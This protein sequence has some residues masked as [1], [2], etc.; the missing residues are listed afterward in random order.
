MASKQPLKL[1]DIKGK[2]I[3]LSLQL[4]SF[5]KYS[6][7]RQKKNILIIGEANSPILQQ[8]NN[9]LMDKWNIFHL[10]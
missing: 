7:F 9:S 8:L 5:L 10:F 4:A 2:A 3:K 1:I 6:V